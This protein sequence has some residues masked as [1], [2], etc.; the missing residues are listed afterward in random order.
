VFYFKHNID[1]RVLL[2]NKNQQI[3]EVGINSES[4][5]NYV[6]N[7]NENSNDIEISERIILNFLQTH[8]Y[9]LMEFVGDSSEM[10][11]YNFSILL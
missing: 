2:K 8:L 1:K 4:N 9:N 10:V 6:N 11:S 5:N 7:N 3:E